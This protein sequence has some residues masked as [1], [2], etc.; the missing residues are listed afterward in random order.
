[1]R[2]AIAVVDYGMGNLHSVVKA[3]SYLGVPWQVAGEPTTLAAAA[4]IVLPGVGA[5]PAA[6]SRLREMGLDQELGKQAALGKPVLGICL[7]MQ[8]LF[9]WGEEGGGTPGLGLLPGAVSLLPPGPKVPHMGWD[10]VTWEL[11]SGSGSA[12]EPR[13]P[14]PG[15]SEAGMS[16]LAGLQP[17]AYFYFVH[18]YAVRWPLEGGRGQGVKVALCHYGV[19]FIAVVEAGNI[20]GTQFHPEKSGEAGLRLLRN[21]AMRCGFPVNEV[22]KRGEGLRGV[23]G[24]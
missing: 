6:T 7:G 19:P 1:V 3:L 12:L 23:G 4:G 21:F 8:L 9:T 2:H 16:L 17:P 15:P 13:E 5:F 18:S 10:A 11:G 20:M 14:V 22:S 24:R